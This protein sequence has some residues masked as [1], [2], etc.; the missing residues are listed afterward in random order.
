MKALEQYCVAHVFFKPG[1]TVLSPKHVCYRNEGYLVL[2]FLFQVAVPH[3]AEHSAS[4]LLCP[5][6]LYSH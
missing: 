1:N 2:I 3:S 6:Q 4:T 5:S